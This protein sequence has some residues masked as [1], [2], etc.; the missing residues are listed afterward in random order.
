MYET[1]NLI[2]MKNMNKVTLLIFESIYVFLF[3]F[4]LQ[5]KNRFFF[6]LCFDKHE[7]DIE[8]EIDRQKKVKTEVNY[9]SS[10]CACLNY[11]LVMSVIFI[12]V[13]W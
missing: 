2:I 9:H 4:F 12:I 13:V 10:I 6:P 8:M 7:E 5:R 3:F 1:R 11:I